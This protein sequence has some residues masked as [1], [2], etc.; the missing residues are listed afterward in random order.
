MDQKPFLALIARCKD[1]PFVGEFVQHYLDEGVDHIVLID[2]GS[3]QAYPSEVRGNPRVIILENTPFS[4]MHPTDITDRLY[5]WI[6]IATDWLIYADVDEYI[7]TRRNPHKTLRQEL[8]TT[9]RDADCVK[10]PWVMMSADGRQEDPTSLL[11]E[12]THRWDHDRR[13]DGPSS[14][15]RKFRCRYDAIEVKCIFRPDRFK[16]LT[17]HHPTDPVGEA[18]CVDGV[19]NERAELSAFHPN[20]REA[21]ISHAFLVCYHYRIYSAASAAKK[22]RLNTY[23]KH[24]SVEDLLASDFS[25]IVD[26]TLKHK[27]LAR[28]CRRLARH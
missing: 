27:T 18:V 7:T 13:H 8:E 9:F 25:E 26:E 21:D 1:E 5:R 24:Y 3:S 20:L 16:G 22:T 11:A 28:F 23:Y 6:T 17:D 19:D 15:Y 2:N 12:T 14:S 4:T 10:V